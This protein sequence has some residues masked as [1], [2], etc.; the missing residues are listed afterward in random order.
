MCEPPGGTY[1]RRWEREGEEGGSDRK[2]RE[3]EREVREERREQEAIMAR[4]AE[5]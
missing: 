5:M 1:G 4:D 2:G 3:G